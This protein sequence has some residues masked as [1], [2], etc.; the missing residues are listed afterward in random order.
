VDGHEQAVHE[1]GSSYKVSPI[2]IERVWSGYIEIERNRYAAIYMDI[3]IEGLE[4]E[5]R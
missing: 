4:M 2:Y 5:G 1:R 3:E